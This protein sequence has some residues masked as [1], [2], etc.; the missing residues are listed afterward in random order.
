MSKGRT[1][2][3][4]RG[5]ESKG[6]ERAMEGLGQ[7]EETSEPGREYARCEVSNPGRN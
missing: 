3:S 1:R 4:Q 7:G 5:S 6:D 2:A